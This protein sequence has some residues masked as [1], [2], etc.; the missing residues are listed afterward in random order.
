[1]KQFKEEFR[2]C[3]VTINTHATG[4]V[5]IDTSNSD[6][7]EWGAIKEFEFMVEDITFVPRSVNL[8]KAK[9]ADEWEDFTM[10]E[11]RERFPDIKATSKKVFIEKIGG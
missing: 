6:P 11:L 8:N 1:M 3:K 7:N 2:E 10:D 5:T 4:R 9:V